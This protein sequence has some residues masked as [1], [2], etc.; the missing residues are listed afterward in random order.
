MSR[1]MSLIPF[2]MQTLCA[3]YRKAKLNLCIHILNLLSTKVNRC[4]D[5]GFATYRILVENLSI[6]SC[7]KIRNIKFYQ[8][9]YNLRQIITT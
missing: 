3:Y 6:F 4:R 8:H 7:D 1:P 5:N 2:D 9:A